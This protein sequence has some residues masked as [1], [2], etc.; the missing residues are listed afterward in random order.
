VTAACRVCTLGVFT[1]KH[2]DDDKGIGISRVGQNHIYTVYIRYFWLGDH[3]TYGHIR[4]IYT[5]LANPTYQ[6]NGLSIANPYEQPC[7]QQHRHNTA[8]LHVQLTHNSQYHIS[9]MSISYTTSIPT[10]LA[11]PQNEQPYQQQHRHNTATLQVQLTH[12]SQYHISF[13]SISCTTSIPT[14]LA[15]P[16]NEQ[17]CQQQHRHTATLQVQLNLHS[18]RQAT[19][20]L[21]P[22]R[23]HSQPL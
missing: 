19:C 18:I 7:Q 23:T 11:I 12:N 1:C 4:C 6:L 20:C 15:I 22:P 13:M 21:P 8:T 14:H 2:R 3:Q 16:Q 5:V 9:F 17:P 10:H